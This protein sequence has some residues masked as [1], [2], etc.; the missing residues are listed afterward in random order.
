MADW[1]GDMNERT[2]EGM[3]HRVWRR[4]AV[5]SVVLAVWAIGMLTLALQGDQ[6]L[7]Q[8]TYFYMLFAILV[9]WAVSTVRDVRRL[10]RTHAEKIGR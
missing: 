6:E 4:I 1:I 3:K 8:R 9:V 2:N 5:K 10:R 7:S